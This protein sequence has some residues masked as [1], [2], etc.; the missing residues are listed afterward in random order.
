MTNIILVETSQTICSIALSCKHNGAGA[1]ISE[2]TITEPMQHAAQLPVLLQKTLDEAKQRNLTI[3]AVAV[4]G[5]PGSYTGLRIGVSTAK[6]LAYALGIPLI[7]VDTLGIIASMIRE[8]AEIQPGDCICPMIDARRMEVYNALYTADLQLIEKPQANI[9]TSDSFGSIHPDAT[10][11][12]GGSGADKCKSV[13]TRPGIKYVD[14]IDP[15]A[16]KMS[17]LAHRMFADQ[18]FVD[19]AYY[20]PFY[21]KEF[22][23]TTPKSKII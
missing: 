6:G 10:I 22:Q 1:I 5:G 17:E 7:A 16:A 23:A 15:I 8:N 9:I 11:Y 21:L 19:V 3:N 18:Q 20:E 12:I 13:I 14:G 2:R 4:S